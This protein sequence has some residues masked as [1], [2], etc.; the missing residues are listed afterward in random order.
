MIKV[1]EVNGSRS[2]DRCELYKYEKPLYKVATSGKQVVV[3]YEGDN[4]PAFLTAPP[5]Q[6]GD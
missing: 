2:V 5:V 4:I 1:P 6:G 3:Y